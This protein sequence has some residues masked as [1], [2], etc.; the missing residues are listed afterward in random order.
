MTIIEDTITVF[1][2]YY[3]LVQSCNRS[4]VL[5]KMSAEPPFFKDEI[6]WRM[7]YFSKKRK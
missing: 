7:I 5:K 2:P 3:I 6:L 1:Y 4:F